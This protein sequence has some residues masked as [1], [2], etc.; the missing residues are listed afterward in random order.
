MKNNNP[1]AF[2]FKAV[3]TEFKPIIFMAMIIALSYKLLNFFEFDLKIINTIMP[4]MLMLFFTFIALK[5]ISNNNNTLWC[6]LNWFFIGSSIAFGL[7]SLSWIFGGDELLYQMNIVYSVND[8][9]LFNTNFLNIISIIFVIAGYLF[10]F[11]FLGNKY[12]IS[13]EIE[14][15][16]PIKDTVYNV[17]QLIYYSTIIFVPF[18]I[19]IFIPLTY[20]ITTIVL[21]GFLLQIS[22]FGFLIIFLYFYL[23]G[24]GLKKY[25]N[26]GIIFA[27]T[28]SIV[29]LPTFSKGQM[30]TPLLMAVIGYYWGSRN[31]KGLL[32][33]FF[34]TLLVFTLVASPVSVIG[35]N[36]LAYVGTNIGVVERVQV[37]VNTLMNPFSAN[38]YS[39]TD[40]SLSGIEH[41]LARN[42]FNNVQN[43]SIQS[44]DTGYSGHT[45]N[46]IFVILVPRIFWP[47]KPNLS[48]AGNE[49]DALVKGSIGETT[50]S[51]A[52]T[53]NGE[54]YW[55]GGWTL[56]LIV[57]FLIGIQ[58]AHF[59]LCSNY[60]LSKKD[61]RFLF[62]SLFSIQYGLQLES[63]ILQKYVGQYVTLWLFW[64]IISK[65]FPWR[66]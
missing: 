6:P 15:L 3:L 38:Q 36:Y 26:I 20:G 49:F 23:Y 40:D 53:F 50:S 4:L 33:G 16:S 51:L 48:L 29:A 46:E 9:E 10:T 37:L 17:K 55:N 45:L 30:L 22:N 21:P 13:K 41:F 27:S 52:P 8:L 61:F 24:L 58:F 25:K 63:W 35:R 65:Y 42:S 62:M 54:A 19:F 18:E 7:G 66:R 1:N 12:F 32:S 5:R 64:I 2:S 14:T 31:I 56:V 59:Y 60:Y 39:N 57:S 44:Y 34:V 47:N 28:L 11:Y 43:F